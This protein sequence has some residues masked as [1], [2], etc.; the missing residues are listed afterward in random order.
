MSIYTQLKQKV[1]R[2]HECAVDTLLHNKEKNFTPGVHIT[3]REEKINNRI[4]I[5]KR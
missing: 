5:Y 2:L 4:K 3:S 1:N